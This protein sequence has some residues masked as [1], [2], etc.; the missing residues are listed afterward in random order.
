[1]SLEELSLPELVESLSVEQ[2]ESRRK[3][4]PVL[5]ETYFERHPRLLADP[6]SALQL[7]YNEVLLRQSAGETPRL[8]EYLRRLPQFADQLTPLFE[9]HHAI[10]SDRL[11]SAIGERLSQAGTLPQGNHRTNGSWP[12]IAG[13]EILGVQGRGGMGVVYKARQLGLNRL[14][15]LKVILTGSHADAAQQARFRTEAEAVARLQHP[16]IVQIHQVG[17]EESCPYYSMEFVD[18]RSL[19]QELDGTPQPARPAAALIAT[20]ARAIHAAHQKGIIHRDLKPANILLSPTPEAHG[21]KLGACG[22]PGTLD[23]GPRTPKIT[24]FGLAKLLDV[25]AGQTGSG[26]VVGTPS[27]MSPE[28]AT[29][30]HRQIGPATDVYSLGA[31]LYELLTGRPP[32]KAQNQMET[33]RQVLS[34][35]PVSLSR[36]DLKVPRDLETVCQKCLRKEPHQRYST[37]VELAEDLERF[38]A[39]RP[40]LARRTPK[41]ERAWR[42]CRRNPAVA[43]MAAFVAALLLLLSGGAW[44]AAFRLNKELTRSEKAERIAQQEKDAA[45]AQLWQAAYAQAI[46]TRK[47]GRV[48]QRFESLKAIQQAAQITR[49]RGFPAEEV[50]ALRNEAAACFSLADLRARAK[51]ELPNHLPAAVD[52][53][54]ERYAFADD[55]RVIRLR[56]IA[57]HRELAS[58]PAIA[59]PPEGTWLVFSPDGRFLMVV[60]FCAGPRLPCQ[61]W[62]LA[63]PGGPREILRVEDGYQFRFVADSGLLVVAHN[64]GTLRSHNLRGGPARVLCRGLRCTSI[65][66]CADGKQLAYSDE[67]KPEVHVLDVTTGNRKWNLSTPMFATALAWSKDS[68]LLAVASA[69]TR[70]YVWDVHERRQQAVLDGHRSRVTELYFGPGAV[71]ASSSDDGTFRLWDVWGGKPLVSDQGRAIAFSCDGQRLAFQN[72]ARMGVCE[73]AHG[74]EC[75]LLH[76]QTAKSSAWGP[77]RPSECIAYNSTDRLLAQ[78]DVDG[79]RFWDPERARQVA[80]L[81]IGY[82]EATFFHPGGQLFTYGR[83]GLKSWTVDSAPADSVPRFGP[84]QTFAVPPNTGWFR[85]SCTPDGRL[86]ALTND[87]QAQVIILRPE[88]PS[89]RVILSRC[90][91]VIS[92]DLSPDGRWVAVASV[93]GDV[94]VGIFDARSGHRVRYMATAK[95]GT[96]PTVVAFSPDGR[97]LLTGSERDYCFWE[98]G[99][100]APGRVISRNN[101]GPRAGPMVF[102][103]DG[104]LLAMSDSIEEILLFDV[105]AGRKLVTLTA[106]QPSTLARLCFNHQGNQLAAATDD[107]TIQLWDLLMIRRQLRELGLDWE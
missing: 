41:W 106:P 15:A 47:G 105:V 70:I 44:L 92:L 100:W 82:C 40:I 81:A 7:V 28:Q 99:S 72:G 38:L 42:W 39:D 107:H 4:D 58:L 57:D 29:S 52:P 1:M 48:G 31:I 94:G 101:S 25:D 5:V 71:L 95:D 74:R 24:D 98:V 26:A 85:T 54:C 83:S 66:L 97:W 55:H 46:A 63:P 37:A 69:D 11:L 75:L 53:G 56:R 90:S 30:N 14:V 60:S 88:T 17:G 102:S 67:P 2:Q 79:I 32:F 78:A 76:P 86:L 61:I 64:D 12:T 43:V 23:V 18:G 33:L 34:N 45:T 3:G 8:E 62:D 51:W 96:C 21:P 103:G 6:I 19:A 20:L 10:E 93:K 80:Q 77:F 89:E 104:R 87:S 65:E 59:K 16:N 50:L 22:E 91:D 49:A 9:V 84:A 35:D 68:R 36:F 73:V 13:H 27:Y